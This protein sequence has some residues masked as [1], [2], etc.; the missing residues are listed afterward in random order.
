MSGSR[1]LEESGLSPKGGRLLQQ[2]CLLG[3]AA[4]PNSRTAVLK[5]LLL[6]ATAGKGNGC[7]LACSHLVHVQL[8]LM[9][10][11]LPP[12][13]LTAKGALRRVEL[14]ARGGLEQPGCMVKVALIT[15]SCS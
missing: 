12:A 4:L 11:V 1:T 10:P 5:L 13:Q 2:S 14:S 15:Y 6:G 8:P 9:L 7:Q 3:W